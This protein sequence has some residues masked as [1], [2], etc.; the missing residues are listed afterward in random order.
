MQGWAGRYPSS[1]RSPHLHAGRPP[2]I[3]SW[4]R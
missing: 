4:A 2:S 3:A 1:R